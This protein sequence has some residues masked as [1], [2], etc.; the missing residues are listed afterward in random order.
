[1][2]KLLLNDGLQMPVVH[3]HRSNSGAISQAHQVCLE[4]Y[5]R[6]EHLINTLMVTYVYVEKL[7]KDREKDVD[8]LTFSIIAY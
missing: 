5:P 7:R 1:M 2:F 4:I 8:W 3:S 6:F